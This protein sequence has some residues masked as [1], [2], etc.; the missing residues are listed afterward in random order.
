MPNFYAET[1]AG[2]MAVDRNYG[3]TAGRGW[4]QLEYCSAGLA[5]N[6]KTLAF[7]NRE[8]SWTVRL[9][10][11]VL[12]P[13]DLEWLGISARKNEKESTYLR[14]ESVVECIRPER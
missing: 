7:V 2:D 3:M 4:T 9:R 14:F 12:I 11:L 13:L 6:W 1:R 5:Q 8:R 10:L